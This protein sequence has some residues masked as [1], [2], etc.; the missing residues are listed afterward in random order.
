MSVEENKA[1]AH[2]FFQ[3]AWGEG[4]LS[5]AEQTF[6]PDVMDHFE[7]RKGLDGVK[8]VIVNF[9]T[10]FPDLKF[11]LE[12]EIAEGDKVVHRW[13]ME[14]THKAPLMGIPATDKHAVWTGTTTVR[15]V[16][17][18]IVERWANVDVFGLLSQLGVI[19][20]PPGP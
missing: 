2:A 10:A 8:E 17:G 19:P 11:T 16:D 9:R 7:K 13:S 20:P 14:G 3:K 1:I 15:F 4:D 5:L 6:D 18:K 12:D